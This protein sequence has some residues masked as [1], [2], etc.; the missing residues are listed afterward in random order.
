MCNAEVGR[1]RGG[2]R[3]HLIETHVTAQK[4]AFCSL[5]KGDGKVQLPPPHPATPLKGGGGGGCSA[6]ALRLGGPGTGNLGSG[7]ALDLSAGAAPASSGRGEPPL[8]PHVTRR[9]DDGR[10]GV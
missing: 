2:H 10:Y 6:Q 7:S 4:M 5:W 8:L 9:T 3:R 1:S